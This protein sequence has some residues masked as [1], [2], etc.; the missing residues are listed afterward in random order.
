[1][2]TPQPQEIQFTNAFNANKPTLALFSTCNNK[3]ELHVIREQLIQE[4]DHIS[5]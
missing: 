2:T 5:R 1:M 3:D 4:V